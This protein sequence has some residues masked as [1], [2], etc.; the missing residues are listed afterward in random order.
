MSTGQGHDTLQGI[1]DV[2]ASK[3]SDIIIGDEFRNFIAAGRG[4]DVLIGGKGIVG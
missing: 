1:R 3:H 4:N 2:Y